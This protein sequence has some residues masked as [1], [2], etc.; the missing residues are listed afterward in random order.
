LKETAMTNKNDKKHTTPSWIEAIDA[1]ELHLR[2]RHAA[3]GTVTES[4]RELEVLR[5]HFGPRELADVTLS[6]LRQHQV[7]LLTGDTAPSG[8]PLAPRTVAKVASIVRQFFAF[9]AA[10]TYLPEDPAL[11]LEQPKHKP[12]EVGDVLTVTQIRRLLAAAKTDPIGLRDRASVELLY[13]TGVRRTELLS[14]DLDDLGHEQRELV[15]RRGKGGKGRKLPVTRSAYEALSTYLE[16]ARPKLVTSHVDS[17]SALLIS[18]RGTRL[19]PMGLKRT[20]LRLGKASGLRCRLHAHMFRRT[21]ATHLLQGGAS[22]RHIQLLLG[23]KNLS[24]TA[25]Y[26][27]LDTSELRREVLLHHPRERFDA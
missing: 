20:F 18:S 7:G 24:T 16:L 12:A 11:A 21:F 22:L 5:R 3:P 23:H 15:V 17:A 6:D 4:L 14:L 1:Y 2:A 25:V 9:L 13:A 27:K 19:D 26:L 10:E 8:R